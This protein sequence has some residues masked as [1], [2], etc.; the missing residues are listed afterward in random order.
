VTPEAAPGPRTPAKNTTKVTGTVTTAASAVEPFMA[1]PMLS[2]TL[3]AI[4]SAVWA[5]SLSRRVPP[6]LARTSVANPPK[7]ANVAICRLPITLSVNANK[8]GTTIVA[9]TA[10]IAAGVDQLANLGNTPSMSSVSLKWDTATV[11]NAKLS[12]ELEGEPS[13]EWKDSFE[14]TIHLLGQGDWGEVQ[15]KKQA[16]RVSDVAP[17]SEDKLRH[18]LEGVVAQANASIEAA[19]SQAAGDEDAD[20]D[21]SAEQGPDAEMTRSFRSFGDASSD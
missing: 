3:P 17:G 16:V 1:V 5:I 9:L 15:L 14:T 6:K 7:A 2:S 4:A 20:E 12:V 8:P 18:H 19:E 21:G 11:K 10:R 13:S